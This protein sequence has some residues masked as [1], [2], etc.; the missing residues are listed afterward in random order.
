MNREGNRAGFGIRLLAGVLDLLIFLSIYSA[1]SLVIRRYLH[2]SPAWVSVFVGNSLALV[3]GLSEVVWAATPGKRM[4]R[5]RIGGA[6]GANAARGA[7][8]AV[9][10]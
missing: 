1:L 9:V 4:L 8:A 5:L 3:Y 2:R 6:D 7:V 10:Y